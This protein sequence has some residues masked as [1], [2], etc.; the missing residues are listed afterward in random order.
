M[1]VCYTGPLADGTDRTDPA[2]RLLARLNRIIALKELGF[3]LQQVHA[4]VDVF[5]FTLELRGMIL[6]G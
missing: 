1:A 6:V 2:A 4:I 3:T 5:L